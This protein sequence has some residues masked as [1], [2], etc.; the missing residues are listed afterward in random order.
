MDEGYFK[1]TK[2]KK[3]QSLVLFTLM[4]VVFLGLSA[5]VIDIGMTTVSKAEIQNAADSA[6]LAGTLDFLTTLPRQ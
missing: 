1:R 6:A 4:M 5:L 3:G 2:R